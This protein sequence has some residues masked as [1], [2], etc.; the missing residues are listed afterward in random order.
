[1]KIPWLDADD[2]LPPVESA[3]RR[4]NGLLAA[5]GGLS[6]WRLVDA[7]RRGCFPWSNP[8]E[9]VLWWSP[10]PRMVLQP[11]QLHV[12]RSLARRV[13]RG[14]F[15]VRADTV[16]HHVIEACAEPRDGQSGTWITADIVNAYVAL[17]EAGFAHSVE[18]FVDGTLVG[19]LYGVAIGQAFFGESMFAHA[20]D[21]SKL[22]LVHLVEQIRRW[23]FGLIDCQM[24]TAHL[25]SFGAREISR[26]RVVKQI[27]ALVTR[28]A[29]PS[30][31]R[32]DSDLAHGLVR[33]R[34]PSSRLV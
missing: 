22:A 29:P 32:L 9:P 23:G 13:R 19:G 4:P 10:D 2:P 30:P 28:P 14:G 3:L 5:G 31:W 7:Y 18:T 20:T 21:A 12:S 24:K 6:L 33:E 1:M 27:A 25:A 8:G 26:A 16:F 17:H 11:D 15:E 34:A